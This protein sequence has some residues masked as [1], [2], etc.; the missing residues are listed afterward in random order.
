MG[1]LYKRKGSPYYYGCIGKHRFSTGTDR[2]AW[3]FQVLRK[4][5]QERWEGSYDLV[6]NSNR[7]VDEFFEKYLAWIEANKR[8]HTLRSYRSIIGTFKKYLRR[9][10]IR[11]LKA[12]SQAMFEDY[13]MDRLRVSK[14]W[15]VNNHIIA[16]KAILNKAVEWHYIRKNPAAKQGRVEVNDSKRIRCLSEEECR[17]FLETCRHSYLAYYPMFCAFVTTGMRA[18]ELFNLEWVDLDFERDLIYIR[19]KPG[20][21]PKG[22]DLRANRAKERMIPIHP[23]LK[24]LVLKM[25]K[26]STYVF[27]DNGKFF[28][29]QRPRRLLI[30]IAKIAGIEGLTRLHELRHSYASLLLS[31]GVHIFALKELLGHSD[32]RDTQKYSHMIPEHLKL[33]TQLIAKIDVEG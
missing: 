4:K 13:I 18:G 26:I 2:K 10:E 27:T 21:A 14:R 28:S 24:E 6:D 9:R 12:I 33:T 16:L 7:G 20:F 25:P 3:A 30:R 1:T 8:Y 23:M 22:K 32:I 11:K 19:S 17:R 15:T 29:K 5:E 31:K